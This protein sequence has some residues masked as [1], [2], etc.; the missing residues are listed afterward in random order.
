MWGYN[1]A[2]ALW[3]LHT[4]TLY[5]VALQ[6]RL[7]ANAPSQVLVATSHKL[8]V[9]WLYAYQHGVL[10]GNTLHQQWL[11]LS[12][13]GVL[14]YHGTPAPRAPIWAENTHVRN[15]LARQDLLSDSIPRIALKPTAAI[16]FCTLMQRGKMELLMR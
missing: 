11:S 8:E 13:G 9:D 10:P 14:Q 6:A 5:P 7:A 12:A 15:T 16:P 2:W 1:V 4:Q 3:P